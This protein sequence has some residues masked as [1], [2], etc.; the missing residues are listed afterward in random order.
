M[1]IKA[2]RIRTADSRH[3]QNTLRHVLRGKENELISV[4]RGSHRD[5]LDMRDDA[6]THGAKYAVRHYAIAPAE[7]MTREQAEHTVGRLAT[8]FGFD[9]DSAVLIE[10]GKARRDGTGHPVHWHLL[11]P[12]VD[13]VRGRCLDAHHMHAR[14]E[15]VARLTEAACGH[16]MV[17]GRHNKAVVNALATEAPTIAA[18]VV[19]A[20]LTDGAPGREAY[21]HAQ[22]QQA[23]R[24]G[25][26]MPEMKAAVAAAWSAADGRV[27]FE[28]ALVDVGLR[29]AAGKKGGVWVVETFDG[30][31]VGSVD[32]LTKTPR[33]EVA[34]RLEK[35][36]GTHGTADR[37]GDRE[38]ESRYDGD[39]QATDRS[40]GRRRGQDRENFAGAGEA[41]G[42]DGRDP[43]R[44]HPRHLS[45]CGEAAALTAR[46][47]RPGDA[48]L[49][50]ALLVARDAAGK[51]RDEMVPPRAERDTPSQ[52][53]RAGRRR[54]ETAAITSGPS[55][56]G[57]MALAAAMAAAGTRDAALTAIRRGA[58]EINARAQRR[59]AALAAEAAATARLRN[60]EDVRR[61]AA[62]ALDA[63][64]VQR[65]RG[66]WAAI[67]GRSRRW[68]ERRDHLDAAFDAAVRAEQAAERAAAAPRRAVAAVG[69]D[70]QRDAE[71]RDA[72]QRAEAAIRA[73]DRNVTEAA[74]HG[75][76]ATAIRLFRPPSR[77]VPSRAGRDGREPAPTVATP[78]LTPRPP[79]VK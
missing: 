29:L 78:V 36:E 5:V 23:K 1:I 54:A 77:S 42:D 55:R 26:S 32:R 7:A 18:A 62:Q 22:H 58:E 67:T 13:P 45:R 72:L 59:A 70:G 75:D 33:A 4:L 53:S 6:E 14:H 69:R 51:A 56:P 71:R 61:R 48:A 21:T 38:N 11:A 64:D 65:P 73:G 57:D 16:Q 50:S 41:A 35:K 27:A 8:E 60:T 31:M 2:I 63:H 46:L 76:I 30:S 9:R 17:K 24:A 47:A 3:L 39:H 28:A 34:E 68:R 25:R 79:W 15:K 10:H 40:R 66:L 37:A 44:P 52:P 19:A 20:G 43:S 12:E 49:A 74:A